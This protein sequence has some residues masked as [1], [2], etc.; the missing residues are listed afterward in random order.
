MV[1]ERG[2]NFG[3]SVVCMNLENILFVTFKF[4]SFELK[5][6]NFIYNYRCC[7][8]E[9]SAEDSFDIDSPLDL[10]LAQQLINYYRNE[11][12]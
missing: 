9:I 2:F 6:I 12:K 8:V 7:F 1:I 11:K 10:F 5:S 4:S 3:H